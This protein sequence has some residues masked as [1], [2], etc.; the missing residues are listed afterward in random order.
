MARYRKIW[1]MTT[2]INQRLECYVQ[3]LDHV[4]LRVS[5]YNATD[6]F[7]MPYTINQTATEFIVNLSYMTCYIQHPMVNDCGVGQ[8]IVK[9]VLKLTTK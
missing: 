7:L 4:V 8:A 1:Q 2:W 9:H 6:V 3:G 5:F